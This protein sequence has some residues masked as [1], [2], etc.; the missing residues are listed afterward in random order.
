MAYRSGH[1]GALVREAVPDHDPGRS[2][3]KTDMDH[4]YQQRDPDGTPESAG[5][6]GLCQRR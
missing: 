1:S 5:K 3:A 2:S 6:L 4:H